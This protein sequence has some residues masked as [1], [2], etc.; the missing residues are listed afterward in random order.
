MIEVEYFGEKDAAANGA[1]SGIVADAIIGG[2]VTLAVQEVRRMDS[3]F[4]VV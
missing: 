3:L 2:M 4:R 1:A